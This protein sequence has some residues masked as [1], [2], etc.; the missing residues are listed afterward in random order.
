MTGE[1]AGKAQLPSCFLEPLKLQHLVPTYL[2]DV[3][4]TQKNQETVARETGSL[5][6]NRYIF[7]ILLVRGQKTY[8]A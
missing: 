5:L 6:C 1:A 7:S 8:Q 2:A 3:S 4:S